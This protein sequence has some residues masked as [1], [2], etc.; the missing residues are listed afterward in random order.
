MRKVVSYKIPLLL[1]V[2]NMYGQDCTK[3]DHCTAAN[4]DEVICPSNV[5]HPKT[6]FNPRQVTFDSTFELALANYDMYHPLECDTNCYGVHLYATPFYQKSRKSCAFARYFLPNGKC[7][8]N[9]RQDGTGDVDPLWLQ[10]SGQPGTSFSSIFA[11]NPERKSAGVVLTARIDF[12]NWSDCFCN[13]WLGIN[14]AIVHANHAMNVCE[15]PSSNENPSGQLTCPPNSTF[16]TALSSPSLTAGK[17]SFTSLKK[18]GLDDIQLKLG[19]DWYYC[20]CDDLSS[21][22]T[23][24]LVAGIPTGKRPSSEFL[25]E[26]LVGSKHGSFGVGL[27]ADAQLWECDA[28]IVT[29]MVDVKYRYAFKA[30][31]RRSYDL[32][33]NL[34]WS[35]YLLLAN[36]A[37]T[38]TPIPGIN[39]LTTDVNV[40]PRSEINFWTALHYERCSW[41]FELG[42]NLWWR[43]QEKVSLS[44]HPA[45][46][47][48]GIFDLAGA[49][50]LNAVS[51]STANISQGVGGTNPVVSDATF[52][53]L[54]ITNLNLHSAEHPRALTHKLY[55]AFDYRNCWCDKPV[56]LGVG[57]SYEFARPRAN[58]LE[59][60]AVFGK[61]GIT[62]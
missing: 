12:N 3:T 36:S 29:W 13:L 7:A 26:P 9:V 59:Q 28:T 60:W 15:N 39:I 37:A 51:A 30:K 14:T 19:Y 8:I 44:Q 48:L 46:S 2:L 33:L 21:H 62:F 41:D 47:S 16:G 11:I 32:C 23:P 4:A 55:A 10:L 5:V 25:F 24:Y 43:Q 53:P 1:L 20:G 58:A 6:F 54:S 38:L 17:V 40:T 22:I 35:R 50:V 57:G 61:L 56:L 49:G 34:D 27:N 42:Y 52:V 31:E 18:T 45:I